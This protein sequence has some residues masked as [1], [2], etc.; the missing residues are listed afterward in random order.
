[1]PVCFNEQST[2]S[3]PFPSRYYAVR[4]KPPHICAACACLSGGHGIAYAYLGRLRNVTHPACLQQWHAANPQYLRSG[5]RSRSL[6]PSGWYKAHERQGRAKQA[7]A[8]ARDVLLRGYKCSCMPNIMLLFVFLPE[9]P[10]LGYVH[11]HDWHRLPGQLLRAHCK[12]FISF[13]SSFSNVSLDRHWVIEHLG[14]GRQTICS[15]KHFSADR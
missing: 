15:D 9:T 12:S 14:W 11:G 5:S 10:K 4:F 6:F 7:Q 13:I 1:L 8:Q 2:A 3:H